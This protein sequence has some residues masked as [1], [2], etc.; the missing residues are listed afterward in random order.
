MEYCLLKCENNHDEIVYL[1]D[2]KTECPLC[3]NIKETSLIISDLYSNE[4][5]S[6]DHHGNC[7]T[8]GWNNWTRSGC[9]HGRAKNFL[10]RSWK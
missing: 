2:G 8:H 9:P 10:E 7:Q 4:K 3:K 1:G 6:L 5:C